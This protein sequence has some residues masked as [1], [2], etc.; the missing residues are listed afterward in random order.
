M[1]TTW[2]AASIA[3]RSCSNDDDAVAEVAEVL[4]RGEQAVVV[5]LVQPDRRLVEH[6]HD[7]G[8]AGADL[9][10]GRMRWAS[11]PDSVS[12]ERSSDR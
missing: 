5:S 3:S 8:Q 9:A 10:R 4:E 11:P 12:A 6:V 1:S 2:S 7:A